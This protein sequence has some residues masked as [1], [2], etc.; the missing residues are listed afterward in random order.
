MG[1]IFSSVNTGAS[2][3]NYT[4]TRNWNLKADG[5]ASLKTIYIIFS[6]SVLKTATSVK[7][8]SANPIDMDLVSFTINGGKSYT[9]GTNVSLQIN[10]SYA[11]SMIIGNDSNFSA[12]QWEPYSTTR[13]WQLAVDGTT[14]KRIVYIQLG[15]DHHSYNDTNYRR[16]IK[17]SIDWVVK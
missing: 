9:A 4:N 13:Q 7:T 5:T 12:S 3:E 16:L 2:W 6:N 11:H 14:N 15:H 8:A 10:C 17:Q 1:G